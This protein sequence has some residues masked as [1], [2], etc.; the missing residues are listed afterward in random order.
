M[1]S[2]LVNTIL[3]N[4]WSFALTNF[5]TMI[6][7][8]YIRLNTSVTILQ[9]ILNMKVFKYLFYKNIYLYILL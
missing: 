2:F 6:L 8:E 5:I 9:Q 1:N 7:N 3:F 4:I